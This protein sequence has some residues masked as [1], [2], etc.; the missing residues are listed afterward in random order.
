MTPPAVS[1][2][3]DNGATSRSNK[4]WTSS[5]LSPQRMAAR[6]QVSYIYYYYGHTLNSSSVGDGLVGVDRL[7]EL[8]SVEIVL[9]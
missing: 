4:S 2:P 3:S 1:I 8:L 5:D 9:E 6:V 7:V